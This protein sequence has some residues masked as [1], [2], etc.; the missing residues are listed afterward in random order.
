MQRTN[1]K[2]RQRLVQSGELAKIA[3]TRKMEMKMMTPKRKMRSLSMKSREKS[4]RLQRL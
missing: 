3:A 2:L 4:L 1:L